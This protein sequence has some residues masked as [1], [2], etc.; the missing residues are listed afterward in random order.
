MHQLAL[1]WMSASYTIRPCHLLHTTSMNKSSRVL[2]EKGTWL[3]WC[4]HFQYHSTL[5]ASVGSLGGVIQHSTVCLVCYHSPRGVSRLV[6]MTMLGTQSL[7]AQHCLSLDTRYRV[8][9]VSQWLPTVCLVCYHSLCG[10]SRLVHMTML[11]TQC[12]T[13]QHCLSLDTRYRVI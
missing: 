5:C 7:T 3:I 4:L 1:W 12:H 10:V 2:S 11:G 9:Q 13:A 8:I 6:H